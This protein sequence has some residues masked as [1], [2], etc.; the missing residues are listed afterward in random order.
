M[1]LAFKVTLLSSDSFSFDR[2]MGE[3]SQGFDEQTRGKGQQPQVQ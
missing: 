2:K 1:M 3:V